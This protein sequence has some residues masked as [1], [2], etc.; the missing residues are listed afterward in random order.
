MSILAVYFFK[1]STSLSLRIQVQPAG[2]LTGSRFFA[3]MGYL[4]VQGANA[5][6]ARLLNREG[7]AGNSFASPIGKEKTLPETPF[8]LINSHLR[9]HA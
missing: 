5:H 9:N 3:M 6:K 8:F 4:R 2:N 7:R 1:K